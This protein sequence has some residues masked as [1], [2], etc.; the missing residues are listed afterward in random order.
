MN[1]YSFGAGFQPAWQRT[2][3]APKRI[4]KSKKP[5]FFADAI[6]RA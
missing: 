6:L 5:S 2:I 3:L 1:A 4:P